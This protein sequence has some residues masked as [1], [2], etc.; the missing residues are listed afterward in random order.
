MFIVK[1]QYIYRLFSLS[2]MFW[3]DWGAEAKIERAV[4]DGSERSTIINQQIN[5]PNSLTIDFQQQR[6]YWVDG[7]LGTVSSSLYNG[8]NRKTV[9]GHKTKNLQFF[10][11]SLFNSEIYL[12]DW[13]FNSLVVIDKSLR[14]FQKKS[15]FTNSNP[16]LVSILNGEA[17]FFSK[18]T[19]LS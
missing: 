17:H 12:T 10:G 4:L 18:N 9:R 15:L 19:F 3:T 2:Y 7:K 6:I 5:W 14:S 13:T 11:I 16:Y 1:Y 8:S